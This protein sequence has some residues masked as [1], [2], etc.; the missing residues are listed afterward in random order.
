MQDPIQTTAPNVGLAPPQMSSAK[1][2]NWTRYADAYD[3]LLDHNPAYQALIEDL[4]D[5][6][7]KA[8]L[9]DVPE[10]LDAGG[11]TGNFSEAL[12]R[13]RPD[14]VLCLA[15]PD[16]GMR[17]KAQHK[18][19]SFGRARLAAVP[20]EDFDDDTAFD[21]IICT[22]ALYAMPSPEDRLKQMYDLVKPGGWLFL[23]DF[24]RQ[25]NVWDWRLYMMRHL[26]RKVGLRQA[27]QIAKEG[28]EIAVQNTLVAERQK[29]GDYWL[30][31]PGELESSLT[32][33]GWT[34][35]DRRVVYRGYSTLAICKRT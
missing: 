15:E 12:L 33:V 28:K 22:H 20:F 9:P 7:E 32:A 35:H 8:D 26:I 23:I 27:M 30:H 14:A 4:Q 13:H 25:M 5:F 16:P 24:G 19:A 10:V 31:T 18:L 6:L 11:G 34:V 29:A 1:A 17:A 2:V 3:L 21:L